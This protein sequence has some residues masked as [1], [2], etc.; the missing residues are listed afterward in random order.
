MKQIAKIIDFEMLE[1][2][3]LKRLEAQRT[4]DLVEDNC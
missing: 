2:W 3:C 1:I 4:A